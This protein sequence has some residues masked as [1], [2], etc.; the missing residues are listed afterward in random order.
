MR[1]CRARS[2]AV[3]SI[4]ARA[5]SPHVVFVLLRFASGAPIVDRKARHLRRSGASRAR[6]RERH[7]DRQDDQDDRRDHRCG[8][9]EFHRDLIHWRSKRSVA[10]VPCFLV[11]L[12]P[13]QDLLLRAKHLFAGAIETSGGHKTMAGSGSYHCII[14]L[15]RTAAREEGVY[16]R[17]SAL[18][19]LRLMK[20]VAVGRAVTH[21]NP[22]AAV[23]QITGADT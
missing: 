12:P 19:S 6:K 2:P 23:P 10:R 13:V 21:M 8:S 20:S 3:P 18:A 1:S 4:E 22:P 9:E 7:P 16:Q 14:E 17:C 15:C 11:S 5:N